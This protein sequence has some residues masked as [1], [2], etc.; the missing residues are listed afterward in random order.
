MDPHLQLCAANY[1]TETKLSLFLKRKANPTLLSSLSHMDTGSAKSLGPVFCHFDELT[2]PSL[3][4]EEGS[5]V[6]AEPQLLPLALLTS[7]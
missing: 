3:L 7:G 5:C 6:P 2:L 4:L 1:A